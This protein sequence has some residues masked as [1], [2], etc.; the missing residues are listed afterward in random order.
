ML[1]RNVGAASDRR[2]QPRVAG[3]G[4]RPSLRVVRL[5][6]ALVAVWAAQV[7]P[8]VASPGI[9]AQQL[10]ATLLTDHAVRSRPGVAVAPIVEVADRRPITGERTVLP[11]LAQ[12][13]RHGRLWLRVR[14]PGRVTGAPA[15]PATGWITAWHTH[16]TSTPWLLFVNL[17]ARRLTVYKDGRIKRRFRAIVGKPASP[18]PTGHYFV[19]ENVI[20]SKGQPGGPFALASSDRSHVYSEFD[21][22]P[23]QIAIHG[24][25]QLGG[26]LGTAES[27]GCVRLANGSI[28]W[29]AARIAPG[30]P[31]TIVP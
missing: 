23:G 10:T 17:G 13:R 24:R 22:G 18:T 8:A 7:A 28:R 9:L 21:G 1:F 3:G 4:S 14:L 19:E 12:V 29:L 6:L 20:L 16:L 5:A 15:P 2:P 26:Q 11:V 27:H 30:T 31:V 25:E